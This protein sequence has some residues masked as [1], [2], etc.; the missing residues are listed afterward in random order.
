LKTFFLISQHGKAKSNFGQHGTSKVW[1]NFKST[2]VFNPCHITEP[3]SP[4]DVSWIKLREVYTSEQKLEE[5]F[6]FRV[7]VYQ[8]H[9]KTTKWFLSTSKTAG[10]GLWPRDIYGLLFYA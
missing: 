8:P 9:N 3:K 1:R 7:V 2:Q 10:F 4:G 5:V 6:D